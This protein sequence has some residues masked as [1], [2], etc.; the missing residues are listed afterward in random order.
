MEFARGEEIQR[1]PFESSTKFLNQIDTHPASC[2]L[3]LE[4]NDPLCL[5][6]KVTRIVRLTVRSHLYCIVGV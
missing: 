4:L 5:R 1:K 3:K 2:G 6:F